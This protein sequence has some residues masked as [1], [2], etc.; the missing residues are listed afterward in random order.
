MRFYRA[1][2]TAH[3][4]RAVLAN[5][6]V[7]EGSRLL[8]ELGFWLGR[9]CGEQRKES[10]LRLTRWRLLKP[11]SGYL[12][13]T[14]VE[15]TLTALVRTGGAKLGRALRGDE[16]TG[17][18]YFWGEQLV[19]LLAAP[20]IVMLA[21]TARA[22]VESALERRHPT[23]PEDANENM[24]E[25]KQQEDA[26]R[27]SGFYFFEAAN[28]MGDA[29]DR[30]RFK[31]GVDFYKVLGVDEKAQG[32]EIKKAYRQLALKN[33]PDRVGS[34]AL[35]Q[36]TARDNMAVINEAYDVLI[37][38][39][40]RMQYDASRLFA[41]TPD[42]LNKLDKLSPTKFAGVAA[43]GAVGAYLL[44]GVVSYAQFCSMFQM[45]ADSGRGPLRGFS[46]LV[47]SPE[48]KPSA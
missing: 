2:Y 45:L 18:G 29:A 15:T 3:P 44:A 28:N 42:F 9:F 21:G 37:N 26:D 22:A 11:F 7:R 36:N 20:A 31:K 39:N 43:V 13:S 17:A 32:A 30:E 6:F 1:A 35:A 47:V 23:T 16:L 12:V 48:E 46:F 33:H 41:D 10:S 34:G 4:L 24:R 19:F 38:D 25:K 5:A 27:A 14:V 8:L 40:T